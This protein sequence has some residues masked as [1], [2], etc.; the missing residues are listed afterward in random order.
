RA[1][2]RTAVKNWAGAGLVLGLLMSALLIG[3]MTNDRGFQRRHGDPTDRLRGWRSLSDAVAK[4]RRDF[5]TKTGQKVFL[6]ADGRDRAAELA[7]YLP[8]K[9][10][11]GPGHPPAY[12]PESQDMVNEFSCWPRYDE[13]VPL[14]PNAVRDANEVY[15][16][17][18]GVNLFLGRTA[19][20]LQ[21]GKEQPPPRNI[22]GGFGRLA[23]IATIEVRAGSRLVRTLH[24]WACYDYR[25][26]PL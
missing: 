10:V 15:T 7:F 26:M 9:R 4:V 12:I 22:S 18:Q 2:A 17:E 5:E 21:E 6:I 19:L 20:Y 24:V 23:P 11:E 3:L 14:P 13:F 8:A 16:E 1:V 25:T